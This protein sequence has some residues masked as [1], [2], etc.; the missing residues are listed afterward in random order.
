MDKDGSGLTSGIIQGIDF[1][2][3]AAQ[4]SGRP[5]IVSMSIGG[6]GSAALD[7]AANAAVQA[8]LYVVVAAGN[9]GI[10]ASTQSPARANG[11][12]TVGAMNIKEQ[13]SSFSNFGCV[14]LFNLLT[15]Y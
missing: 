10:D 3:Q 6:S 5:S 7:N 9:E 15:P 1:A 14:R 4:K 12:I 13:M 2:I 11:V 8:G